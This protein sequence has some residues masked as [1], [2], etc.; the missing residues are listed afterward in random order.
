MWNLECVGCVEC[1]GCGVGM[2]GNAFWSVEC[3]VW[4]VMCGELSVQCGIWSGKQYW[5][6]P[7]ASS[8]VQCSTGKCLVQDLLYKVV[9]GIALRK[10]CSVK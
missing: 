3:G 9:L 1:G 7:C 5:E 8:V 6:V 2:I 10:I 4:D